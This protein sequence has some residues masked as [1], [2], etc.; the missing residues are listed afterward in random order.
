MSGAPALKVGGPTN[1]CT[2]RVMSPAPA[3]KVAIDLMHMPSRVRLVR[4]EPLPDG[5]LLLLEIAAG[6]QEAEPR[7][8][9]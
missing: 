2:E 1:K 6:D 8:P 7:Q 4:S 3:L 5:V 9:S